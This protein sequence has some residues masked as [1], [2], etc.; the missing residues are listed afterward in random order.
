MREVRVGRARA[1]GADPEALL[2]SETTLLAAASRTAE[3]RA[4]LEGL[5]KQVDGLSARTGDAPSPPPQP[6]PR[7]P[8]VPAAPPRT[9][10]GR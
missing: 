6:V 7:A 5:R 1:G 4:Q 10:P 9:A 3:L 8:Q 2:W